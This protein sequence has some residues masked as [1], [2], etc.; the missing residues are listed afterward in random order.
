MLDIKNSKVRDLLLEGNIGLEKES[1]RIDKDGYFALTP[2]P[3]P[4]DP[5]IV[6][7]FCEN[8]TEINTAV[9]EN[10]CEAMEQ[11]KFHTL[12]IQKTLAGL[13]EPEYLWPFSN[14]PY[15]RKENEIPIAEYKDEE[16]HK[17]NYR[18]YLSDRY[19]RYKMTFSGIH[20][21]YSFSDDLLYEDFITKYKAAS[22]YDATKLKE[23]Y[24]RYKDSFYM[25]LAAKVQVYNWLIVAATAASPLL[26]S[27]YV[28]KGVTGKDIFNGMGS[29]RC[30]ELGYWNM[31]TPIL[32]Y[33]DIE[34]YVDSI[35]KYVEQGLIH[36]SAELYYPV[37]LKPAGVYNLED[38]KNKG[39]SH[40][41]LRMIDLNPLTPWGIE[42]KD[43]YFIKLLLSYLAAT[44]EINVDAG[45]QVFA[46]QNT[47]N[48]AHYDLKTVNVVT[49][50]H[51]TLWV[52]DAAVEVLKDM[53][54][55]YRKVYKTSGTDVSNELSLIEDVLDY[56]TAKFEDAD[57][58]YAW[59]IRKQFADGFVEKGLK[60][61]KERADEKGIELYKDKTDD[62]CMKIRKRDSGSR[63]IKVS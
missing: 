51:R 28:E 1:L 34:H 16:I 62:E 59:K 3:F 8:Q 30:S 47:K 15:I 38:L 19:G 49:P 36:S 61:C 13:E 23:E 20:F 45:E 60:L 6:R 37:R 58:R 11:L 21:N 63:E 29:T 22:G 53:K 40:I 7:D 24:R 46:I 27:S 31:F 43:V 39:V 14:P 17:K 5:F 50:D 26:D 55:F 25:S 2:H 12:R 32:D 42:E 4:N 18:Y 44:P 56:Q 41:E 33:S 52:A 35:L 9:A 10:V 57:N 48:A 54:S